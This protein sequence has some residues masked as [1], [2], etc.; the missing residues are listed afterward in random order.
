MKTCLESLFDCVVGV[1]RAFTSMELDSPIIKVAGRRGNRKN[2]GKSHPFRL[3]TDKTF[4]Y[5][6]SEFVDVCSK[7][8][9]DCA[10]G[11]WSEGCVPQDSS[12]HE[13]RLKCKIPDL[14]RIIGDAAARPG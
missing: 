7:H 13:R 12:N 9:V 1:I 10:N 3:L 4:E 8:L 14:R 5:S 6:N 2:S 11:D